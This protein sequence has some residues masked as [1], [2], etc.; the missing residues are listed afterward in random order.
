M[1]FTAS[2]VIG[3][4]T[5]EFLWIANA[6]AAPLLHVQVKDSFV[7]GQGS[8]QVALLAAVP[9]A[10]DGGTLEMNSGS[11]H[12]FLAEAVW[13]PSALLP[14][15]HLAWTPLDDSRAVATLTSGTVTVALEFRF[16]PENEVI[17]IYTPGR[18]GSFD[19]VYR[20]AAWE[21]KFRNYTRR[22]GVLVPTEG[23]VGWYTDGQWQSVWRGKVVAAN[24]EFQ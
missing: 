11:L 5:T 23:E 16:S 15:P 17:S 3:P 21:G 7:G 18:W 6:D 8:G 13:Y 19:G 14:S 22:N 24:M 20:Q 9:I 12:R 4:R 10:S 1:T 2:Q